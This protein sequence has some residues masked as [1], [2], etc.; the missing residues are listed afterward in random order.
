MKT[1]TLLIIP[2]LVLLAACGGDEAPTPESEPT[3]EPA[4]VAIVLEPPQEAP[5][6]PGTNPKYVPGFP[7]RICVYP[8]PTP[9]A[10][11][12]MVEQSTPVPMSD[13]EALVA[14]QLAEA[15]AAAGPFPT[16]EPPPTPGPS[17]TPGPTPTPLPTATPSPTPTPTPAPRIAVIEPPLNVPVALQEG[18]SRIMKFSTGP[19][20]VDGVLNLIGQIETNPSINPT[21]VQL[22]QS[23]GLDDPNDRD[24]STDRPVALICPGSGSDQVFTQQTTDVTWVYCFEGNRLPRPQTDVVPWLYAGTWEYTERTR[25]D[26]RKPRVWDFQLNVN[27]NIEEVFANYYANPVGWHV[28]IFSSDNLIAYEWVPF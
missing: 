13:I 4:P 6:P 24:C 17:P 20:I 2:L 11:K 10:V 18:G 21:S 28:L 23:N 16:A 22:W 14:A 5:C 15:L 19:T 27:T 12:R 9:V 25:R 26:S 3:V 8:E 1:A 7:G